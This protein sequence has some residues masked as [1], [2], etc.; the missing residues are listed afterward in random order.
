MAA[1]RLNTLAEVAV[2]RR[3]SFVPE[4][5]NR[6]SLS[7]G[8]PKAG[9]GGLLRPTALHPG[10]SLQPKH[11]HHGL[12]AHLPQFRGEDMPGFR[13]PAQPRQDDHILLA[14][15]LER[16]R[17][18]REAGADI[19]L[20]QLLKGC[21]VIGR[22]RSVGEAG[23]YQAAGGRDRA[24]VVRIDRMRFLPDLAGERIDQDQIGLV[25][26]YAAKRRTEGDA[27]LDRLLLERALVA[28][29]HRW[30]VE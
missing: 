21:V 9:P 25:A 16:H 7:S 17:R 24:A 4:R 12:V 22:K 14:A 18:R 28:R 23:E 13:Y 30:N 1:V 27:P 20:P 6:G 8:R 5:R 29:R 15:G 2:E 3:P 26:L 11:E 10:Y 19:D